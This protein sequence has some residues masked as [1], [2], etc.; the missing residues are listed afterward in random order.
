[1]PSS[2]IAAAVGYGVSAVVGSALAS[3]A[4]GGLVA[5]LAG[6]VATAGVG[7][8][9]SSGRRTNPVT[10]RN[11][12]SKDPIGVREHVYGRVRKGGIITY[13]GNPQSSQLH[14]VYTVAGS[15]IDAY[16]TVY[17]DDESVTFDSDTGLA[18]SSR[19]TGAVGG[20]NPTF[21]AWAAIEYKYGAAGENAFPNLVGTSGSG[22]STNHKQE[23]CASVHVTLGWNPDIYS[24]GVPNITFLVRGRKVYD[25]RTATTV[26]SANP[27]LCLADYL[28]NISGLGFTY[29][30][31]N[32]DA[33]IA[34]AN[35]CDEDVDLA[36]GGTENRY[37]CHGVVS[38]SMSPEGVI[39]DFLTAMAG[40]ATFIGGQWYIYAGAYQTPTETLD[41]S[42]VR[43]PIAVNVRQSRRDI[44]N[45][46]KGMFID[47]TKFWQ[48]AD[49]PSYASATYLAEDNDERIWLELDLPF[50]TSGS[51][52]QRVVK[53][54]LERQR[55]QIEVVVPCKLSAYRCLP[56]TT[57]ML[58][59]EQFGWTEKVFEV[60]DSTFTFNTEG[61]LGVDLILREID[62]NAYEWTTDEE[63]ALPSAPTTSLPN[64]WETEP[65]GAPSFAER[66]YETTGSAGV[67]VKLTVSW[68]E[69]TDGFT[70]AGGWYQL[71]YKLTSESTYKVITNI[72]STSHEI[73]DIESGEYD[74]RVKGINTANVSSDYS[75]STYSVVGLDAAPTNVSSFSVR[76][77]NG[78]AHMTWAKHDELDVRIGGAIEVRHALVA[79]VN[80]LS[81]PD[82]V[83]I[84]RFDGGSVFG[85]GPLVEGYYMA[86][87]RDS[88]L[89][90]SNS[91]STFYVD[92]ALITGLTGV[93]SV[94]ETNSSFPGSK[95][96]FT[97][98]SGILSL[99]NASSRTGTYY[100]PNTPFYVD[101]GSSA[102]R[103]YEL[104]LAITRFDT[105]DFIDSRAAV[106]IWSSVDGGAVD[107][108]DVQV[109]VQTTKTHPGSSAS[110]W[111]EWTPFT[112][113][114]L[115]AR[116]ARF[117]LEASVEQDTH[118]IGVSSLCVNIK[119][120]V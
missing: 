20:L 99:T 29:A 79:S 35:I 70:A 62:S 18:T 24:G 111:S 44:Y 33:L 10:S 54:L 92:E 107:Q 5:G 75:T 17:F 65:P 43:G 2:L 90:Y 13:M 37:E 74:F 104:D 25:P 39:G 14:I 63:Q 47:P 3:V 106:D 22:W 60:T 102:S 58:T 23:G 120:A 32:E 86:K 16:E 114:D 28:V 112:V 81:W 4:I 1:M 66:L 101:C 118:N 88:S 31:I 100:F 110:I 40:T 48:P 59:N 96:N 95:N 82:S 21:G 89:N 15:E 45:G 8:L 97:F 105:G 109:Y 38:T 116:G 108:G 83:L 19:Y 71:E 49:Y 113:T 26:Y 56:G 34:A 11:V 12:S 93:S 77:S 72:K 7:T 61:E 78:Y 91:F 115:L 30:E 76:P 103:R 52:A 27:A 6:A 42:E 73:N 9:L 41:E 64:A 84:D 67:K 53:V 50:T 117:K 94:C 46:V 68:A 69:S 80:L 87:A 119:R 51:M 36:A 98:S 85:V 57:V 55:R